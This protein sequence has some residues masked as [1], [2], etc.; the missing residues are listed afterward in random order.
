M[1]ITGACCEMNWLLREILTQEKLRQ[2]VIH[3]GIVKYMNCDCFKPVHG[4]GVLF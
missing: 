3:Q 2:Q 1:C 4:E